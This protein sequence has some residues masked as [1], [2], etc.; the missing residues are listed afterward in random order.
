MQ[1]QAWLL[2]MSGDLDRAVT[3]LQRVVEDAA[4]PS[5]L[6]VLATAAVLLLV[7]FLSGLLPAWRATRIDPVT[8][9]R[10]E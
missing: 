5:L 1:R 2:A 6:L 8:V 10:E 7:A 9:L 4:P 3:Q